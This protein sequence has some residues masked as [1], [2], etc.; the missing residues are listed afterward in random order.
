MKVRFTATFTGIIDIEEDD[1]R[2]LQPSEDSDGLETEEFEDFDQR[3][4]L[5]V[6]QADF[7]DAPEEF[8]GDNR[9][10]CDII[11]EVLQ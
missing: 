9:E 7:D 8:V 3:F 5:E 4:A 10:T 1:E 2:F 11:F 6:L